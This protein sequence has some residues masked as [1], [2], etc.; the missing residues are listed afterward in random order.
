MQTMEPSLSRKDG[1]AL[2]ALEK[3][4]GGFGRGDTMV[5]T[6]GRGPSHGQLQKPPQHFLQGRDAYSA[7]FLLG[8][9]P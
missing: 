2:R 5:V 9:C 7:P 8:W 3:E 6:Q 1:V 4:K